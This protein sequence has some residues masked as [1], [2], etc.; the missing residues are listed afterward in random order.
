M[1]TRG[2]L[3]LLMA[4]F[5]WGTTFVAQAVGM[6]ELGPFSYAAARFL[7]GFLSLLALWFMFAS[8]REKARRLGVYKNGWRAGIMAGCIMFIASST[9]QVA[10]LY[11]TAGKTAFITCLYIIFVPIFAVFLNQKIRTANWI[12]ALLAILGLYLLAIQDDFTLSFGDGLVLVSSFFWTA[13]IL[14]IDHF[15]G[16]VDVVE[17]SA[18]Q[19]GLCM[20]MSALA[21]CCLEEPSWP[22]MMH[23]SFAI[24]YGGVMSAGVAFTLQIVGQQYAEPAHAAILMSFEAVFGALASWALLGEAMSG[25]EIFGC[26]LML[27]G[28]T[29]SQLGRS[30]HCS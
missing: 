25:R 8:R 22:A 6:D 21:A 17:L 20:L 29:I 9:Q 10:L 23:A 28:M 13:H 19:I 11:T 4:A 24:F 15:A 27:T 3:M 5:I 16:A 1:Q 26:F 14:F 30:F 7:L 2:M 12:G 18:G